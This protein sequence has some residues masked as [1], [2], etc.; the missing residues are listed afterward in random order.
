MANDSFHWLDVDR[1]AEELA[2]AYPRRDPL[3]VRFPELRSLVQA[4]PGFAE[5]PGHVVN[6]RIL[7][8][9]QMAWIDERDGG[10]G[11]DADDDD[12]E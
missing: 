7:E 11:H 2:L 6:E 12:D 8:A 9:I 4:L 1:I 5:R 10:P 3:Q